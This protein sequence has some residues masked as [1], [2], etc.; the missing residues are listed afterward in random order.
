MR[1]IDTYCAAGPA[2]TRQADDYFKQQ[3]VRT[4]IFDP[5][6]YVRFQFFLAP[7]D[8]FVLQLNWVPKYWH[9]TL[10]ILYVR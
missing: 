1:L 7:P 4:P 3:E 9:R 2:G 8:F 5:V 6:L 10:T